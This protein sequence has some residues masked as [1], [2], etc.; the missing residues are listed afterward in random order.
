M[1]LDGITLSVIVSELKDL[2][3]AKIERIY[4]PL[5]DEITIYLHSNYFRRLQ[6]LRYCYEGGCRCRDLLHEK[7]AEHLSCEIWILYKVKKACM[8]PAQS[9]VPGNHTD[10]FSI[11]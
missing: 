11:F 1:N 4:Q 7:R 6:P 5:R 9:S 10:F 3:D 2:Y 8:V